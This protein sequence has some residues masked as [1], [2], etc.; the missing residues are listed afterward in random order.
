MISE[1]SPVELAALDEP[2]AKL[3]GH[4]GDYLGVLGD[5]FRVEIR[6]HMKDSTAAKQACDRRFSGRDTTHEPDDYGGLGSE[7]AV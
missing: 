6:I 2:F 7:G 3:R 1:A 4:L 5:C